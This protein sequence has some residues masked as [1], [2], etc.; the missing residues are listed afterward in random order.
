MGI[1][2]YVC[3]YTQ[4]HRAYMSLLRFP[5]VF[6]R[7]CGWTVCVVRMLRVYFIINSAVN[8][9]FPVKSGCY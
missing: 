4:I 6:L 8:Y 2:T 3:T 1:N 5:T 7:V 9:I